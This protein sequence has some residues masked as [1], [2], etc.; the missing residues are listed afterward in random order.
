MNGTS[1][2]EQFNTA[3][4]SG[5]VKDMER[6]IEENPWRDY[7]FEKALEIAIERNKTD[8]IEYLTQKVQTTLN[9]NLCIVASRGD[10]KN[11][12][13]YIS[14]GANNLNE[15]LYYAAGRG[16]RS[17]WKREYHRDVI[18]LLMMR[19]AKWQDVS[20]YNSWNTTPD[21]MCDYS[22]LPRD[23]WET[24]LLLK[25]ITRT[26]DILNIRLVCKRFKQYVDKS[27]F[28][29]RFNVLRQAPTELMVTSVL[30]HF[31]NL[32]RNKLIEE[33]RNH[34][35]EVRSLGIRIPKSDKRVINEQ[36]R[37]Q[38]MKA[39]LVSI[40]GKE[41]IIQNSIDQIAREYNLEEITRGRKRMK[42]ISLNDF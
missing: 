33:K 8:M 7:N 15:A 24:T 19:G 28:W 30:R 29:N 17:Y 34:I 2:K 21:K 18:I 27:A 37:N 20:Q 4:L 35:S 1:S 9:N 10:S 11:V 25:H 3:A 36:I 26:N 31:A 40:Q 14:K 13:V 39:R 16:E 5:T 42:K 32:H 12:Q 38:E 41:E 23:L 22:E 6:L